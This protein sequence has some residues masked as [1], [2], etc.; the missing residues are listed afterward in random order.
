MCEEQFF[1]VSKYN[2]FNRRCQ[3]KLVKPVCV[4]LL[5]SLFPTAALAEGTIRITNGEWSPYLSEKLKYYGVAS[6]IVTEAFSLEGIKAEYGFF[7][8]KRALL[9]AQ[10]GKWDGS[11]VWSYT[12]DRAKDF[13]YS[14]PVVKCKWVFFY[15]KTTSFDWKVIDDLRGFRIG[16]TLGYKYNPDFEAAEEAGRIKV[17]RVPKDEQNF[18][19]LIK[20]RIDIFLQD[21]DV[22]Y[23]M[24][25]NLFPEEKVRLFTH[26]PKPIKDTGFHL[27]LSKQVE[28][29]KEMLTLFDRGLKRLKESGKIE[30]YLKES[31][32]GK[33]KK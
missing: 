8:W 13:Y 33:Y 6:R 11:V 24:L 10:K 23:E 28:K 14:D 9:L 21:I 29:N 18:E 20:G 30:Q 2:F 32:I 31:R 26:H 17:Y 15:L 5:L 16:G 27:L 12:E 1:Q 7:P 22:G 3:M 19:K 25:N 4:I